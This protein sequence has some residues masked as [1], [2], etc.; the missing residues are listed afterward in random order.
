MDW[1]VRRRCH[2]HVLLIIFF[3]HRQSNLQELKSSLH[4]SIASFDDDEHISWH[5][6]QL[7]K[8]ASDLQTLHSFSHF[9]KHVS[10]FLFAGF[11]HDE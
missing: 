6:S 3:L 5:D 10:S 8:Q 7:L 11:A 1:N 9:P 4:E 2:R